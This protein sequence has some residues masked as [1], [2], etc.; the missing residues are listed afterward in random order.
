MEE[1]YLELGQ[2]IVHQLVVLNATNWLL[3]FIA[4]CIIMYLPFVILFKI[5]LF[6][7]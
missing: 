1:Q 4:Y 6:D 5:A 2:E 7:R 3:L